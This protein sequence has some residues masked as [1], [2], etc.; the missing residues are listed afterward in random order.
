[1]LLVAHLVFRERQKCESFPKKTNKKQT[2]IS[3]LLFSCN[4]AD[5]S[6]CLYVKHQF[7]D[8]RCFWPQTFWHIIAGNAQ[9]INDGCISLGA[10]SYCWIIVKVYWGTKMNY[11]SC[12]LLYLRFLWYVMTVSARYLKKKGQRP[13]IWHFS[14]LMRYNDKMLSL[15]SN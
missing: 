5:M 15:I 2:N 8:Y 12:H 1:M 4:S 11:H 14:I 6:A 10:R 13:G 3:L 7:I 9:S